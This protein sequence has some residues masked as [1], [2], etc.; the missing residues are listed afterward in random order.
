VKGNNSYNN[1]D[2]HNFQ[3]IPIIVTTNAVPP[4][5]FLADGINKKNFSIEGF[6]FSSQRG[7]FRENRPLTP[8]KAFIMNTF[9]ARA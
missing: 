6:D 7:L 8:A 9:S 2:N 1:W 3:I 4:G 5:S